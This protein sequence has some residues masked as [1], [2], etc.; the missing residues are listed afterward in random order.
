M[1]FRRRTPLAWRNLTYRPRRLFA[2]LAGIGF[3]VLLI[4]METGFRNALFDSTVE[5]IR[6]LDAD[7]VLISRAKHSLTATRRF[8]LSRVHAARGCEGVKSACP[9]Y[10]ELA[11]SVWRVPGSR[12]YPIRVLAFRPGDPVFAIPQVN[13]SIDALR[14]SHTA[15]V[16]EASKAKYGLPAELEAWPRWRGAELLGRRLRIVGSF[17]LGTDFANDGNLVMSAANYADCFAS[18]YPGQNPLQFVNIGVVQV[19]EGADVEKVKDR[20]RRLLPDDMLVFGKRE[21]ADREIAFWDQSTPIGFIFIVG[22]V[23]GFI[24][25]VVICYQVIYSNIADHVA[26]LATL[27][28]MGYATPYF[29]GLVL[30]QSLYLSLLGFAPGVLVSYGLYLL[31]GRW[32]GL[33]LRLTVER[34]A[35]V[36]LLTVA[37]CLI[38][39]ALAI[40]K[41]LASDPA[42]LF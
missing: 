5:I 7:I 4:F 40:R 29:I 23:M 18:L 10:V 15:L 28:A 31:L 14:R 3:A 2:A 13:S 38:S 21:Y 12:G 8:D 27:K 32:T 1:G 19:Q 37:M 11:Y 34:A 39:G 24:V 6:S 17:Q 16:D 41:V 26:E 36:L 9:L 20:L 30:A 25:G 33:L 35:V 42:D 22:A